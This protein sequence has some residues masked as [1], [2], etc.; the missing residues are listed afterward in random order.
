MG[1]FTSPQTDISYI[2]HI[3]LYGLPLELVGI[4]IYSYNVNPGT[5][6]ALIFPEAKSFRRISARA[7]LEVEDVEGAV[8]E[9]LRE[10]SCV[11]KGL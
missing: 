5:F 11:P 6:P 9:D 8:D 10:V 4:V 2:D 3:I 1:R 7:G